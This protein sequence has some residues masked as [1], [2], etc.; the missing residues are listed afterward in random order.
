M[1]VEISRQN[2]RRKLGLTNEEFLLPMI[3]RDENNC[4]N[5]ADKKFETILIRSMRSDGSIRTA[6]PAYR[7]VMEMI[8]GEINSRYIVVCHKC[9]NTRCINPKHLYLGDA[10]TN[11][12]DRKIPTEEKLKIL[13]SGG[14]LPWWT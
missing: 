7:Q 8:H 11:A 1:A 6:I 14:S 3:K 10:Q 9:D 4:W 13:K 5:V 12:N 2:F